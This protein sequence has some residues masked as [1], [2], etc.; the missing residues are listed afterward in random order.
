MKKNTIIHIILITSL[1]I[2]SC[3]VIDPIEG[4]FITD[5]DEAFC[6]G[7]IEENSP[8]KVI[9][10]EEF[11]GHKCPNCPTATKEVEYLDSI[12]CDHIVVLAC[13]PAGHSFTA[14]DPSGPFQTNFGSNN[15]AEISDEF[16]L[17][18]L[19]KSLIN[20]INNANFL[21][22]KI[23]SQKHN[24][25]LSFMSNII[26]TCFKF[27]NFFSCTLRGQSQKKIFLFINYFNYTIY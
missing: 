17:P 11:T 4:S 3:D 27:I 22:L 25:D 21:M 24:R 13:H 14:P 10:I 23:H 26:K 9:L 7:E 5:C 8:I 16:G 6:C 18:S 1:F 19:P 12:Y 2:F 20:R 15:V